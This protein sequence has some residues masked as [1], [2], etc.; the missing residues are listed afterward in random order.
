[1]DA[2]PDPDATLTSAYRPIRVLAG[3]DE[4]PWP[5][6]LVRTDSGD[7]TVLVDATRFDPAWPGWRA[8]PDGHVLAA[9]DIVRRSRGHEVALPVCGETA[10]AFIRRRADA[11]AP[12]T[13]GEAVTLAVSVLRGAGEL[14]HETST[15]GRWWIT[16]AGRPVFACGAGADTAA[17]A[18]VAVLEQLSS[19]PLTVAVARAR[20]VLG[21]ARMT[22]ADLEECEGLLFRCAAPEPLALA[23]FGPRPARRAADAAHVRPERTREAAAVID[24]APAGLLTTLLRHLDGEFADTLSRIGTDLWRR[25]RRVSAGSASRRRPWLIAAGLAAVVVVA[26]VLWPTSGEQ[27]ATAD[28]VTTQAPADGESEAPPAPAD[29]HVEGEPAADAEADHAEPASEPASAASD[30]AAMLDALLTRRSACE[31]DTEC[32]AALVENPSSPL[33]VGAID[34]P[35]N[36]RTITLVDEFGGVAVLRVEVTGSDAAQ[37]AVVVKVDAGWLIRD[38]YDVHRE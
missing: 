3:G 36:A 9:L 11:G 5:G 30:L 10:D 2:A 23:V 38:V 7:S 17:E 33:P 32:L 22:R 4:S 6:A 27:P 26:G 18:A 28:P 34:V 15:R 20:H 1:M 35:A 24:D 37:L 25:A 21:G 29:A 19:E 16:D 31:A 8:D 14:A 12:L 13:D